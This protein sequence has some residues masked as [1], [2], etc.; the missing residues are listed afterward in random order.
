MLYVLN[1]YGVLVRMHTL[2]TTFIACLYVLLN[3]PT[4]VMV[5]KE[6]TNAEH[7]EIKERSS[8]AK[9]KEEEKEED[10]TMNAKRK[11]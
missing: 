9:R 1:I 4:D 3:E 11:E 7:K 8:K 10:M 2:G 5:K 6:G